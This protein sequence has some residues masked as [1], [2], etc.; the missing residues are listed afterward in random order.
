RPC[1]QG[2][3][4]TSRTRS[5]SSWASSSRSRWASRG[6]SRRSA[7]GITRSSPTRPRGSRPRARR[8]RAAER[9]PDLTTSRGVLAVVVLALAPLAVPRLAETQAPERSARVGLLAPVSRGEDVEGFLTGMRDLGY[10]EGRNLVVE[11][12]VAGGKI[13]RLDDLLAELIRLKVDVIVTGGTPAA[14]AAQRA[15]HPI[16]G[17][18]RAMGD[19]VE[20]GVVA[21]LARP[22][23]SITGLSL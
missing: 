9:A 23:G 17:V 11:Y 4:T 22:G 14:L 8:R 20:S 3:I 21:S 1:G 5:W 7:S 6:G 12:R 18:I 19:P 13:E 16:P 10:V 2:C 15:R